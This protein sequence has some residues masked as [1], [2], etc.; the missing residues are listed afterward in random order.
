M[1]IAKYSSIVRSTAAAACFHFFFIKAKP[2]PVGLLQ[3]IPKEVN[4]MNR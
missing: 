4:F 3:P 1:G 2:P